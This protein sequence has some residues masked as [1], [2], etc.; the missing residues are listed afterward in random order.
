MILERKKIICKIFSLDKFLRRRE[1]GEKSVEKNDT[2]F[3]IAG[4]KKKKNHL[5]MTNGEISRD[6]RMQVRKG[7]RG[8]IQESS[9]EM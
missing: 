7:K 3:R 1:K 5:R 2:S 4:G 8:V 9:S 6:A